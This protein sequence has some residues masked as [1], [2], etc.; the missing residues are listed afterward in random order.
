MNKMETVLIT[1]ASGL[2]GSYLSKK[3]IEKGY[4][5]AILGRKSEK[6]TTLQ[7][8]SWNIEKNEIDEN[9]FENVDYIIHLAGANIGDRRWTVK[10]K[11][12]ILDS[13]IKSAQLIFQKISENK[14]H[15]KAFIT[16][17]AIGYY[18][19]IT[20]DKIF[21]ETD[22][23]S[24]DFLGETCRLWE[25]AAN[26][27]EGLGIRTVKIRTGIVLTNQGGALAK[28]MTPVKVGLGASIGSGKQFMPWIHIDDLCNIYIKALEDN[29]MHGAYNAVAPEH[30]TNSEFSETLTKVL[31]KAVWV[32]IVP[33]IIVRIIFG[34]MA[35]L[36]LNG[37]RV[38]SNKLIKEG[39]QFKF[40]DLS[41]A[42]AD[43][44]YS[45][46]L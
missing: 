13:R 39:F 10:R 24:D 17:S 15:L 43:L 38:S 35:E 21:V 6:D 7:K 33:A 16:A 11:K 40:P 37:S 28:M 3:L 46:R 42:L 4:H 14:Q 30:K 5:V 25:N 19:A 29:N 12:E 23:A 41:S 45:N 18:G 26:N 34:K 9:A 2:V 27:F 20:S 31:K 22:N 32:P 44:F 1:G 36:V 8:F